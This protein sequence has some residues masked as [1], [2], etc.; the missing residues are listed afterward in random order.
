MAERRGNK[1]HVL[2][3]GTGHFVRVRVEEEEEEQPPPKAKN[4]ITTT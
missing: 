2:Y 3:C 1:R 4:G